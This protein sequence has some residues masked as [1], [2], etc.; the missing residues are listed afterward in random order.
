MANAS[1]VPGDLQRENTDEVLQDEQLSDGDNNCPPDKQVGLS[2]LPLCPQETDVWEERDRNR[3]RI[4]PI[5]WKVHQIASI[6]KR[7]TMTRH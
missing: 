1:L 3:N 6:T 7:N 2:G 5:V 4:R